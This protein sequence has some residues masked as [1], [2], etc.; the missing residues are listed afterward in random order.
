VLFVCS[1]DFL[2]FFLVV[3]GLFCVHKPSDRAFSGF[4]GVCLVV[5]VVMEAFS[6][7]VVAQKPTG[8]RSALTDSSNE[9]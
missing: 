1:D 2:G 9:S 4:F 7:M 8:C 3:V 6:D 5:L